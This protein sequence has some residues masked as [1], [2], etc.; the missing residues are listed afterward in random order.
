MV[1]TLSEL[2]VGQAILLITDTNINTALSHLIPYP[3]EEAVHPGED[4][5]QAGPA[6]GRTEGDHADHRLPVARV[7]SKHRRPGGQERV[8]Y[9]D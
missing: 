6:P 3:V 2:L 9:L 1:Y 4:S 5:R 7:Q 8:S